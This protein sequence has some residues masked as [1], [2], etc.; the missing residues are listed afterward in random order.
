[1]ID[2]KTILTEILLTKLA[3]SII[4]IGTVFLKEAFEGGIKK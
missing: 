2:I 3:K 4:I 1:M